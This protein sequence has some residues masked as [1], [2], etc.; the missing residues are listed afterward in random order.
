VNS[1]QG[2]IIN[3]YRFHTSEHAEGRKN[4]NH[5]VCMKGGKNENNGVDYYKVLR[6]VVKVQFPSHW[7]CLLRF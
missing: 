1:F 5:G 3:G 6:E 4:V 7:Y 2:Y